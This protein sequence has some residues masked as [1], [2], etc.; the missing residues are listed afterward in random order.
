MALLSGRLAGLTLFYAGTD[1]AEPA[2]GGRDEL[3]LPIPK[4]NCEQVQ[5]ALT[6]G[7][8]NLGWPMIWRKNLPLCR[9]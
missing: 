8:P 5:S 7:R 6:V 4:P 2:A 1:I 9:E 3:S